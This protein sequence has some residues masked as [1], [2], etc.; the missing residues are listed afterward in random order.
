M[1]SLNALDDKDF[2]GKAFAPAWLQARGSQHDLSMP[3]IPSMVEGERDRD[4]D[5]YQDT[6]IYH[7][8]KVL[9]RYI[10][11]KEYIEAKREREEEGLRDLIE[12]S[13]NVIDLL[14]KRAGLKVKVML[15]KEEKEKEKSMLDEKPPERMMQWFVYDHLPEEL[16]VIS[17][18]FSDLALFIVASIEASP[19][20]T[21]ALRKLLESKDAAVRAKLYKD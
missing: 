7:E 19:E 21:V 10:Q 20:R 11:Y 2:H 14:I 13:D 8:Y 4:T 15:D 9:K 16:Q 6:D 18:P 17:K 12:L 5:I 1:Q 3:G